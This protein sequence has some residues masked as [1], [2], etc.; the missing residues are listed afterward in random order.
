VTVTGTDTFTLPVAF[1]D[2]AATKG[3][4]T[5]LTNDNRLATTS[6]DGAEVKLEIRAN[7]SQTN[8][9][10]NPRPSAFLDGLADGESSTDTFYYAVEDN[11]GAVSLA[12]LSVTVAGVNNDPIPGDN[13][14]GL[15]VLGPLLTGGTTAPQLLDGSAVL[16]PLPA[17]P[18]A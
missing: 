6:K 2:N 8:V 7:R 14:P 12:L 16:H 1:V 15:S 18:A 4:W 5:V 3:L 9:V 17:D 13:P 11:R 10:Y